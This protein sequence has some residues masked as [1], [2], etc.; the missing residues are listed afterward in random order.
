MKKLIK[1]CYNLYQVLKTLAIAD[2]RTRQTKRFLY[3]NAFHGG[4][5]ENKTGFY[6]N[7]PA[8]YCQF[9]APAFT[10]LVLSGSPSK[11]GAIL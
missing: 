11:K 6:P 3:L 7:N 1:N 5:E 8:V 4:R 2:N 10:H 9:L